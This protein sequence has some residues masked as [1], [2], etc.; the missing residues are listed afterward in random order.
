MAHLT[1]TLLDKPAVAP[2]RSWRFDELENAKFFRMVRVPNARRLPGKEH[3]RMAAGV[4]MAKSILPEEIDA[5]FVAGLRRVNID[6]G[7]GN[8]QFAVPDFCVFIDTRFHT[9]A[10]VPRFLAVV[11]GAA[12]GR[13]DIVIEKLSLRRKLKLAVAIGVLP[14]HFPSRLRT[15]LSP[16]NVAFHVANQDG[17]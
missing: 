4:G 11:A 13:I 8:F 5:K 3:A 14:S 15:H 10:G 9:H 7:E 17:H 1:V 6:G 2:A 16:T 12:H